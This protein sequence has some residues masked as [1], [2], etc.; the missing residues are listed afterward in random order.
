[1]GA[2]GYRVLRFR[3]EEVIT[4]LPHVLGKILHFA[5][6]IAVPATPPTSIP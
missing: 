1:L 2:F 4:H 3:N 5:D 6:E